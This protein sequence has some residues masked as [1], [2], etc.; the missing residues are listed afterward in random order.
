MART[1]NNNDGENSNAGNP[2]PLTLEQ[3]LMMQAQML[4]TMQQT[5]ANMQQNQQAPQP[6][7]RDK[8]EDFQRTKP[9]S[10]SHC[11]EPM[12]ADDWLKTMEKKLQIV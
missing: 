4:Q 9:S 12:D 8:L 2:P 5:M 11:V 6:Q 10:F 7:Q 3:V 1:R